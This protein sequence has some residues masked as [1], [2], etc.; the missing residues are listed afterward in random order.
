[1]VAVL[2]A[3][4]DARRA[5]L[6]GT[7]PGIKAP[8][9]GKGRAWL[10][11]L[12]VDRGTLVGTT[13]LSR[14]G[15]FKLSVPAGKYAFLATSLRFPGTTFADRLV[16]AARLKAGRTST[17]KRP[18]KRRRARVSQAPV[19][20]GI[21][22]VSVGYPAIWVKRFAVT[23]GGPDAKFLD[24]GLGDYM[25]TLVIPDAPSCGAGGRKY[26]VVERERIKDV[27]KE[28]RLSQSKY[29]DPAT[30]PALGKI[31]KDNATVTGKLDITGN[32]IA[33]SVT[34]TESGGYTATVS[35]RGAT[36]ELFDIADRLGAAI[37]KKICKPTPALPEAYEGSVSGTYTPPADSSYQVSQ[38][39]TGTAR[40]ERT[41]EDPSSYKP[42]AGTLTY[43]TS[44]SD[45]S[46]C[47]YAGTGDVSLG[48][49]TVFGSLGLA[50]PNY[51]LA[52]YWTNDE[53]IQRPTY[54]VTVTCPSSTTTE[55][56]PVE[57]KWLGTD[58]A[59]EQLADAGT[60]IGT[61]TEVAP[62]GVQ[63]A[64]T[65]DLTAR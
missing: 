23:G 1:M 9:P 64:W 40:F 32:Q 27:L 55:P 39:W 46:G 12:D 49:A 20:S 41:A 58:P 13:G 48:P 45:G 18:A 21:G 57:L 30:R 54:P 4:A 51:Y 24:Q 29:F 44:G 6:K 3:T 37:V 31:I 2:P 34:Y 56:T 26:T 16:G 65:W 36:D 11:A 15:S 33:M 47:S 53:V 19:L 25:T 8:P 35:A 14:R 22:D 63:R 42:V 10:R 62:N 52:G 59:G 50:S 38:R 17:L 7:V 5:T 28:L 61:D 60:L 43:T